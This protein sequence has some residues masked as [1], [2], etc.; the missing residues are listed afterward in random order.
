MK[1]GTTVL[2]RMPWPLVGDVLQLCGLGLIHSEDGLLRRGINMVACYP[3][4]VTSIT[5][6]NFRK[7]LCSATPCLI[8]C[9]FLN[10]EAEL[11]LSVIQ[12]VGHR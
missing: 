6:S 10:N 2:R 9:F 1:S 11:L 8:L 12:R 7:Y 4:R 3:V 5:L